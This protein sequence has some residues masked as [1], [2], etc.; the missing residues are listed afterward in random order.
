MI[1]GKADAEAGNPSRTDKALRLCH[2]SE[3]LMARNEAILGFQ[4]LLRALSEDSYCF[5]AHRLAF[6]FLWRVNDDQ[7]G[8]LGE[9]WASA[10]RPGLTLG[11][12]LEFL[13]EA[14][15]DDPERYELFA[16]AA[17]LAMRLDRID[18]AEN[19]FFNC[20]EPAPDDDWREKSVRI[21]YDEISDDY[22]A[23]ALHLDTARHFLVAVGHRMA[24]LS[25]LTVVD[26][27]CGTG[28]LASGLRSHAR[29]LIGMDLSPAMAGRAERRYDR[30]IVG[31]MSESLAALGPVADAVVCGG[32]VYYR[33]DLSPFLAGAAAALKPGGF[34]LFSEFPAPD[35]A[36]TMATIGGTRRYCRDPE[37]L[38][39]LAHSAGFT[40][41][42]FEHGISY[43]LPVRFWTFARNG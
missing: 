4:A 17:N 3:A 35:G 13:I 19:L 38:C 27:A 39:G 24:G 15:R 40:E 18:L 36:G 28:A 43:G 25:G 11:G 29:H 33:P 16:A 42:G 21:K 37:F 10:T 7:L 1:P 2:I 30:M 32:A 34:V 6:R 23:G 8:H 5:E 22:D 12:A 9:L 41:M 14:F 31:D 20:L 26:A